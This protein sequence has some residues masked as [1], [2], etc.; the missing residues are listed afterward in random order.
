[1]KTLRIHYK[2]CIRHKTEHVYNYPLTDYLFYD[3]KEM[4]NEE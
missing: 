3:V 4:C 2:Y 1:M